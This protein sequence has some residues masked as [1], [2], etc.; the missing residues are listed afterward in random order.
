MKEYFT[1]LAK[2]IT[3]IV[4]VFVFIPFVI[5]AIF[6]AATASMQIKDLSQKKGVAVVDLKGMI[7]DS[8]DVVEDL[9]KHIKDENVLGIVLN[10]DS[11]GGSVAP[12]QQIYS[13]VKALKEEKPIIAV[14]NSAAASG[15]LY[16]ALGAT[17]IMCQP[18]TL[19]G[20][21]GVILQVP[22][23][24]KITDQ[25]GFQMVTIKSGELKDVGNSFRPMTDTDRDFLQ[26]SV[27][28]VRDD[29]VQAVV[30]GRGLEREKVESFADGRVLLGSQAV[31]YGLVDGYGTVYDAGKK[32]YELSGET[33][34]EGEL[35]N[36]IRED[37]KFDRIREILE[38]SAAL[39]E[40]FARFPL[41]KREAALTIQ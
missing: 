6:A 39:T 20:S 40:F 8:K 3:V 23:V 21:I 13:T 34:E 15:G 37:D 4:V 27:N 22:N 26:S 19:T 32:I 2:F 41:W 29:F 18:G 7:V 25:V 30:D 38:S 36:L 28:L 35:P 17:E 16:S 24:S 5:G 1:W 31:E 11:P 10:I 12:S 9:Y 14:M 33:L